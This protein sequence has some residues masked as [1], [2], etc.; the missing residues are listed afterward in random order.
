M[1]IGAN[2][3]MARQGVTFVG[4]R[5][6]AQAACAN[7]VHVTLPGGETWR[8]RDVN[9]ATD[10]AEALARTYDAVLLCVKAYALDP[11]IDELR[12]C[13][14]RLSGALFVTFQNGVGSEEKL[15]AAF[16]EQR[17]IAAT[18]TSPIS[19]EGPA[20]VRLERLGGGVGLAALSP[21]Q[22]WQPVAHALARAPL[23]NLKTYADWRAMKWSKLLLNLMGNA[24]SALLGAP[25]AEI[26][27]DRRLFALE[28]HMLREALAVMQAH[29]PP[30][31]AVNLP[32]HPARALALALRWLPNSAL[33]VLLS[34]RVAKG[35]GDKYPSLYYDVANRSGRSE[36]DVL[37]GAVAEAGR[38]LGVPT[39]VNTALTAMVQQAVQSGAAPSAQAVRRALEQWAESVGRGGAG[40]QKLDVGDQH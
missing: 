25:V 4:R 16:G 5:S 19:I 21:D 18:L 34:R 24:T 7:G 30:I 40:P 36:V 27:N 10:L 23:L 6:F 32:G 39:P 29:V 37:N 8:L 3:V 15:A 22:S 13:A 9:V 1:W 33:Q 38:K 17:T 28:M 12:R 26:Y 14:E 20:A 31:A 35:R 2:L 11:A